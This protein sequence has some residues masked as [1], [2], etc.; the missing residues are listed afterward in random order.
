[1]NAA[2]EQCRHERLVIKVDDL[3]IGVD[4]GSQ[5]ARALVIDSG[6]TVLGSGRST[7]GFSE[8]VDGRHEQ[9]PRVWMTA[10]RTAIAQAVGPMGSGDRA[11]I[12]ALAPTSTSGTL[13]L[14]DA[15]GT[16]VR[17]AIMWSDTRASAEADAVMVELHGFVQ[18][19]GLRMRGSF[20][21]PKLLWL[22][23]HEPGV[24]DEASH[25]MHASDYLLWHLGARR[26]VTDPTNALKT[27]YDITEDRWDDYLTR[28]GLVDRLP[29]VVPSGTVVGT[30][31]REIAEDVGISSDVQLVAAMTDSNTATLTAGVIRPGQWVTTL[32]TGMSVKGVST[33][34]LVD[35]TGSVYSHRGPSGLWLPSGTSHLGAA[36]I[37]ARFGFELDELTQSAAQETPAAMMV[38]PLTGEG[39]YFP[40]WSP[41][42]GG[43][44][45]GSGSRAQMF[46]ATLE[47]IAVVEALAYR[48]FE[49]LGATI[50]DSV[51]SVGG[52]T[53]SELFTRIRAS[54]LGRTIQTVANPETAIGAGI[55]AFTGLG[56]KLEDTV[57]A[58]VKRAIAIEPDT[59]LAR[60]YADLPDTFTRE[61]ERREL[62][63]ERHSPV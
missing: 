48:R 25:I 57:D 10:V 27:G 35:S 59:Q 47:G 20:P 4:V 30:V 7:W 63:M 22:S 2:R 50:G 3:V 24:I 6:G 38:Y 15:E 8:L 1:M 61:F 12:R 5:G 41:H 58:V 46:R 16:P 53:R 19:T 9:D 37:S 56:R 28:M 31:D 45:T 32:G 44:T 62:E 17:Q 23:T 26:A 49:E 55:L 33:R 43:F 18:R 13:V 14:T 51:V 40:R 60:V 42:L 11:R 54:M 52:A 29:E 21:L 34:Q 39:D 36:A